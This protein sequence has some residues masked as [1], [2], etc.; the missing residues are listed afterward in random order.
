MGALSSPGKH[1]VWI[2]KLP[3]MK[4][5]CQKA[6]RIGCTSEKKLV[7]VFLTFLKCD[8]GLMS[9]MEISL[10]RTESSV[11]CFFTAIVTK[12]PQIETEAMALSAVTIWPPTQ[13]SLITTFNS[14]TD[15]GFRFLRLATEKWEI[16]IM[17]TWQ[18]A[19]RDWSSLRELEPSR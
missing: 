14:T 18:E 1:N 6:N 9:S 3:I 13:L 12:A 8:L 17:E 11:L 5:F 19:S 7:P 16:N 15:E 10:S 2:L 4:L